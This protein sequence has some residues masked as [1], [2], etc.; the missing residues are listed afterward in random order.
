MSI[1]LNLPT[2]GGFPDPLRTALGSFRYLFSLARRHISLFLNGRCGLVTE[3]NGFDWVRFVPS[4]ARTRRDPRHPHRG[5]IRG[6][7]CRLL[8]LIARRVGTSGRDRE[9][10]GIFGNPERRP[11]PLQSWRSLRRIYHR[12][13]R[14]VLYLFR[15]AALSSRQM[16]SARR[17][18]DEMLSKSREENFAN[19]DFPRRARAA[20]SS[21]RTR[22]ARFILSSINF[23]CRRKQA[24]GWPD[25]STA[26][27]CQSESGWSSNRRASLN[28]DGRGGG[29]GRGSWA[30]RLRRCRRVAAHDRGSGRCGRG[31]P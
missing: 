9:V 3:M 14:R 4:P 7:Q 16:R 13:D 26:L 21:R 1:D 28:A 19:A 17:S 8:L 12:R 6:V 24:G 10:S 22:S 20:P 25:T 31:C 30:G 2:A 5:S 27:A 29:V 23:P 11:L 15:R 18:N